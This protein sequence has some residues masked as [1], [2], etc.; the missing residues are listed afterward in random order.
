MT[1]FYTIK[2]SVTCYRLPVNKLAIANGKVV[3]AHYLVIKRTT[4]EPQTLIKDERM[5]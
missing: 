3:W 1:L 5:G 2:M 4:V